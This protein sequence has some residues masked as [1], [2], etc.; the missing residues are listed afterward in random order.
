MFEHCSMT[1]DEGFPEVAHHLNGIAHFTESPPT[2]FL[3]NTIVKT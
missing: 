2:L 1:S 3:Y